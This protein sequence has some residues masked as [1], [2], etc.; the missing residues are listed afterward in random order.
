MVMSNKS[1]WSVFAPHINDFIDLKRSLGYKYQEEERILYTFD[2]FILD[3][4]HTIPGLTKEIS[5]KWVNRRYNGADLTI[6][7]KV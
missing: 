4:D 3:Q 6:Y 2:Q 7:C 5:D 1:F